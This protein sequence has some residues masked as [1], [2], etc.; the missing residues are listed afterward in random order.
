VLYRVREHRLK[1]QDMQMDYI[2]F[3]AGPK[4]MVMI[5]GLNTRGIKGAAASLA[6]MYRIFAKDFTVYVFSR[7]NELPEHYTTREMAHDIIPVSYKLYIYSV[8]G[9]P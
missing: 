2:T 9:K 7:K 8:G 5:Q 1:I 4:V 3:G 6:Y